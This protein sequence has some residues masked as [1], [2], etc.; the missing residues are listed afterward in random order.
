MPNFSSAFY[1]CRSFFDSLAVFVKVFA[2]SIS[3]KSKK[4]ACEKNQE[5]N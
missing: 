4:P 5:E 1:H 2:E 3:K